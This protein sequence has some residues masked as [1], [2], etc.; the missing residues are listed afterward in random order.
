[1]GGLADHLVAPAIQGDGENGLDAI[2]DLGRYGGRRGVGEG[3]GTEGTGERSCGVE[4]EVT[5]S[6]HRDG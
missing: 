6:V 5:Y 1:M 2:G 3:S 4:R